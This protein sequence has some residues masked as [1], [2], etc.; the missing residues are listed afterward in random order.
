MMQQEVGEAAEPGGGS[1]TMPHKRNPAGCAIAL[2]AAT[3]VPGLVAAFLS[4]MVQE[5]E[6][7]VGGHHAEA[8]TTADVVQ[9]TGAAL[10]AVADA[11]DGLRIDPGRMLQ[12]VAANN[13]VFAERAMMLIAPVLGREAATRV[14]AQAL[15]IAR[16]DGLRFV[17]VLAEDPTVKSAADATQL[18]TLDKPEEYLGS[19]EEFRRRLLGAD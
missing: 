4:G 8:V 11:I 1:S 16:R 10:A 5:H 3:R 18:A 2:A 12:N 9:G 14:I 6:R 7:G 13:E 17:D 15:E 19:A